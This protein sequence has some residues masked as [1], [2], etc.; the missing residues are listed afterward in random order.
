MILALLLGCTSGDLSPY[1]PKVKFQRLDLRGLDFE[2]ID[3][4]FVFDV[5]NPNPVEIPL[6]R[7]N[8]ALGFEGI[9]I[10]TGDDPNG[11]QLRAEGTSELALP[12]GLEFANLFELVEAT[13]GQDYIGFGLRGGFGF[14]TDLG[15]V[16]IEY[17]EAGSFPAL[18]TPK[19]DLGQLQIESAD[20]SQVRFGLNV[21]IDND[22]GSALDFANLDFGM[23]FAGV[24]V[25]AG[26]VEHVGEV[27]GATT[28]TVSIPF[29][30]DYL[31]AIEA[32]TA[33]VNGDPI[34]VNLD[35]DVDVDT[36]FEDLGIDVV[37]L[38]IDEQGNVNVREEA[39]E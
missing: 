27:D 4:D 8:Y 38:S 20:A 2:R 23:K 35:A 19:F 34:R 1:L 31:D 33:A 25:S 21:D 3:V 13:R 36:P 18:R 22:H 9:D 16:D 12:V 5:E 24:N 37:P 26:V 17:D 29:E 28:R 6:A 7:F 39:D 10:L 30:V 15:P 32:V 11:L 14:D